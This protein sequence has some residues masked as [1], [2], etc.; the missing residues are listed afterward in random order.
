MYSTYIGKEI[1][2]VIK[3][4]ISIIIP[5]Y[6]AEQTV[7]RCVESIVNQGIKE[8]QVILVEDKSSD[9]SY[10]VCK[11]LF[12]KYNVIELYLTDG[13]GV[14]DARNTGL[15]YVNGDIV[16]FCD[17]DD[18]LVKGALNHV[19]NLFN[20]LKIDILFTGY[21]SIKENAVIE[22]SNYKDEIIDV[23]KAIEYIMCN[24]PI[25]GS[26]CNKYY[27]Y[28]IL[29]GLYF[30][31]DL[32]HFEDGYFNIEILTKNRT[33]KIGISTIKTYNYVYSM[34]SATNVLERCFDRNGKYNYNNAFHK[35]LDILPLTNKEK[36][37]VKDNIFVESV[38]ALRNKQIQTNKEW[39]NNLF[40]EVKSNL[41]IFASRVYKFNCRHRMGL[42]IRGFRIYLGGKK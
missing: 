5:V 28:D 41:V 15:K 10:E 33:A 4:K 37:F 6:N 34:K 20:D 17:A 42:L 1:Y 32:T 21:N 23:T 14:S 36:R 16:G 39:Y 12:R 35:V 19:I 9:N 30:P 11:K 24:P 8:L 38:E 31:S 29:N 18:Y 27:R 2:G 7:K 3:L 25:M 22:K 26:V 40:D 13:K